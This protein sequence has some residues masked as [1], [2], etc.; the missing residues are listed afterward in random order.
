MGRAEGTPIF[1][2]LMN[3]GGRGLQIVVCGVREFANMPKRL[4]A[5]LT[6]QVRLLKSVWE[7]GWGEEK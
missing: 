5:V 2:V 1:Q 6:D 3:R 7:R 4:T